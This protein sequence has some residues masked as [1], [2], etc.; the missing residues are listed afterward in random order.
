MAFWSLPCW[1]YFSALAKVFCLLKPNNAIECELRNLVLNPKCFDLYRRRW[2]PF[3]GY[4]VSPV[5]LSY[6]RMTGRTRPIVRPD[7]MNR[8]VT[9]GYQKGVYERVTKGISARMTLQN[10]LSLL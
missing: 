4:R 2:G 9:K 5:N 1:T 10:H 6:R 3:S 7:V 8:M